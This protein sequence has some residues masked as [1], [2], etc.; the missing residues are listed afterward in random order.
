VDKTEPF[1][2]GTKVEVGSYVCCQCGVESVTI[3]QNNDKL[4]ICSECGHTYWLKY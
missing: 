4:P 2:T 3:E 1:E